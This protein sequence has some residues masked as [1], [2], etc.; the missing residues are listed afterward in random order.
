MKMNRAKMFAEI[1]VIDP[2]TKGEVQVSMFKHN[3]GG[4]FGIDSSYI[5]QCLPEDG[6]VVIGDPIDF[7]K[8]G[9]YCPVNLEG[10]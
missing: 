1:T 7:D 4:I 8:D 2:D 9:N 6:E 3:N 10:I 5:D